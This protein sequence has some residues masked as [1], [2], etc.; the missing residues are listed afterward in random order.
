MERRDLERVDQ[1]VD[2]MRSHVEE[3]EERRDHLEQLTDEARREK[4]LVEEARTGT[5]TL[6]DDEAKDS[7]EH[8]DAAEAASPKDG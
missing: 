4:Q 8:Q 2:E 6:D 3:F 7:D 5:R 1:A